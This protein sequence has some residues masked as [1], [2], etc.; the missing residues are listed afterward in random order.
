MGG[1]WPGEREEASLEKA[2]P[3][4]DKWPKE[5]GDVRHRETERLAEA[6]RPEEREE[7]AEGV[8]QG[9]REEAKDT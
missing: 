2:G 1:A 7:S 3:V 6:V 8:R 5:T 4:E 9:E